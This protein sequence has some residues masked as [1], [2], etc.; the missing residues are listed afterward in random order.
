MEGKRTLFAAPLGAV[1]AP[2]IVQV[3][4]AHGV[5]TP[6]QQMYIASGLMGGL[7]TV[8]RFV[9]TRPVFQ[10]KP[11][12]LTDVDRNRIVALAANLVISKMRTP[13]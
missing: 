10:K 8:M 3:L 1:L 12:E 4:A 13:K 9:T 7:M 6:D 11:V 5:A 2:I